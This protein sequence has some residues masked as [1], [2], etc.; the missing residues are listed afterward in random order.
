M[1]DLVAGPKPA[2]VAAAPVPEEILYDT[3]VPGIVTGTPKLGDY[4]TIALD[5]MT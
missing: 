2:D 4:G 3:G 1:Y 5:D